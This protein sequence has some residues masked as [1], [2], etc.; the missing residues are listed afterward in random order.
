MK[1]KIIRLN[2]YCVFCGWGDS[3]KRSL[4]ARFYPKYQDELTGKNNRKAFSAVASTFASLLISIC[5]TSTFMKRRHFLRSLQSHEQF[6]FDFIS[7][8][9]AVVGNK[10]VFK[11]LPGS[12]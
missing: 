12:I 3:P 4:C 7:N 6:L 2:W 10:S 9:F 5:I 8:V 11:V 1:K